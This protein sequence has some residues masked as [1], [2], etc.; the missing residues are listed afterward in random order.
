MGKI[1]VGTSG[2][3]YEDWKGRFYPRDMKKGEMLSFYSEHFPTVEINST[4]YV[5]PSPRT[6]IS[7]SEKT[8]EGFEFVVKANKEITHVEQ[9][10]MEIYERFTGSIQPIIQ[11]GRLG[12]ILAQYPWA[13]KKNSDNIC[14]LKQLRDGF[15]DLPVTVEFRN[16][17]WVNDGTFQLLREN[18]LGYCCVDE[19]HLK[20]MMPGITLST[21]D[22]G[23]VRFH[24]R[25]AEK[26][27][28]R[29][30]AWE[31]YNY[32]Y[33]HEELAEWIPKVRKLSSETKKTYIFFN[34]HYESKAAQNAVMFSMMLV[35]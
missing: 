32:L 24:G 15:G 33:S 10:D 5:I 1:L 6:F 11:N 16:V 27:W 17:S 23:Y 8:P 22:I 29:K 14:R 2:F 18:N 26:W 35:E 34:N 30:Q 31:R 28:A 21:T 9:T 20:G 13:F 12:C 4:Y 19:P 7:M 3:S 25:N